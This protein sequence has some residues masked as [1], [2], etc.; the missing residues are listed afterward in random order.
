MNVRFVF[1]PSKVFR[2]RGTI[3]CRI[4]VGGER[5]TPFST[6]I[7]LNRADWNPRLQQVKGRNERSQ[8]DNIT[9]ERLRGKLINIYNYF[10]TASIA[11]SASK[12]REVFVGKRIVEPTM[13]ALIQAYLEAEWQRVGS[14][15]GQIE[16]TT[17]NIKKRRI[18]HLQ[19]FLNDDGR[20]LL[21][22]RDMTAAVAG[23]WVAT[24]ER[25]YHRNYI[26][27]HVDLLHELMNYGVRAEIIPA[28]KLVGFRYTRQKPSRPDCLTAAEISRIETADFSTIP[29]LRPYLQRIDEVRDML[30]MMCATGMHYVDYCRLNTSDLRTYDGQQFI[31]IDRKKSEQEAI[32]PLLPL[33]G[34]LLAKY[35]SLENMP[36]PCNS[37]ANKFLKMIAVAVGIPKPVS[38]K[39]GRRSLADYLLN[40][41]KWPREKVQKLLGLSSDEY[42]RHYADLDHRALD[43]GGADIAF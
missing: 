8:T 3:Q 31:V 17:Y 18:S 41:L 19:S 21:L 1:R 32:I 36:R 10:D 16:L 39:Y 13:V 27:K 42:L 37:Q 7:E 34:R 28:N 15:K 38:T 14:S 11:V 43:L 29:S 5:A 33:A 22:A 23:Q 35:G 20:G 4:T 9:L 12:I 30:L 25:S 2:N 6:G 40:E 26:A 24:M